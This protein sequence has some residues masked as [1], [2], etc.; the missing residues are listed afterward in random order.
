MADSRFAA[1]Y[2]G[3][4]EILPF[5]LLSTVEPD[6]LPSPLPRTDGPYT[7]VLG[8]AQ[9]GGVP[10]IG[11]SDHRAWNDPSA[12]RMVSSIALVDPADGGRWIFDTTP[13][14]K[15]QLHRLDTVAPPDESPGLAGIFLTHAHMG[16]Y[17][18]LSP[19][20]TRRPWR[21]RRAAVCDA[22]DGRFSALERSPGA[23]WSATTMSLFAS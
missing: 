23:S 17:T 7:V 9:D 12:R 8:I 14:F 6:C 3:R 16:H 19:D 2:S 4:N 13:D 15:S 22:S 10:Q 1:V 18:G 21:A 5:R 11:R 20:R